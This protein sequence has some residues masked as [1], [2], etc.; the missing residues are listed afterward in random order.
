MKTTAM[1]YEVSPL[2]EGL[3][4][5]AKIEG[6]RREHL[7]R[8]EVRCALLALWID[9]GVLLFRG[10][11]DSDFHVELSK[12]FGP[13]ERHAFRETWIDGHPEL[14]NIKYRPQDGTLYTV[15][16]V[17]RGG[18]LPWHS[19]LIYVDKINRGG[20]LRAVQ[21]PRSGGSTGFIDQIAAYQIL[22]EQVKA[23]IEGLHVVYTVDINAARM[24]FGVRHDVK[25][26]RFAKS[27]AGIA[28]RQWE[29]PRV[30]HPMVFRQPE[31][32][33]PVLNVS[34]YF[35]LGI[36]ELGALD[37]ETLLTEVIDH[38][39]DESPVYHHDWQIGD[40]VLWDNWRTLHSAAGVG[41]DDIRVMQRTTISGDYALGRKLEGGVGLP[42]VDV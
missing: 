25:L 26:E 18:W 19:D 35:A 7:D 38:C 41:E 24:R 14:V 13:L 23:R 20:I 42:V 40:M 32:G 6:L 31:T 10:D 37:G 2:A 22:P 4:F 36:Y 9:R 39:I 5:G 27:A 34:P 30:L 1:P 11:H 28:S 21:L 17:R 33:R 3:D 12:V 15:D 8:E 16:G 29:Y